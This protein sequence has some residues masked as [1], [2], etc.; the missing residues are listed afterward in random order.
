LS[1]I[2][3]AGLVQQNRQASEQQT[4]VIDS[5]SCSS[6]SFGS[7]RAMIQRNRVIRPVRNLTPYHVTLYLNRAPVLILAPCYG[8]SMLA[9]PATE[10]KLEA[11]A[12]LPTAGG[13]KQITVKIIPDPDGNGWDVVPDAG[14]PVVFRP[15]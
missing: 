3:P 11:T 1:N 10:F 7:A 14:I 13:Q 6:A 5:G 12:S 8:P 15:N 2:K 9:T 4:A